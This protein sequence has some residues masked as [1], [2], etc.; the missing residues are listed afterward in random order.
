VEDG[1]FN[2]YNDILDCRNL[3]VFEVYNI[4]SFGKSNFGHP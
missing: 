3:T 4:V 1:D 2:Q